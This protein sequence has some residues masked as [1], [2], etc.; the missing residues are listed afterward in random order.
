MDGKNTGWATG[1]PMQRSENTAVKSSTF[2]LKRPS[3]LMGSRRVLRPPRKG[4]YRYHDPDK[5]I[6]DYPAPGEKVAPQSMNNMKTFQGMD[7]KFAVN[8]NNRAGADYTIS[9]G[10]LGAGM[11]NY[12]NG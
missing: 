4:G 1:A 9:S 10:M 11:G 12:G 5:P 8:I 3:Y 6:F 2:L 7:N